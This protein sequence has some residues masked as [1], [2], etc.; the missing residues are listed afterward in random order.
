MSETSFGK[1]V[2]SLSHEFFQSNPVPK[3]IWVGISGGLD[4]VALLHLL[5]TATQSSKQSLFGYNLTLKAIHI[6]HQL[7]PNAT[8]WQSFCLE[9]CQ[10]LGIECISEKIQVGE[11][12]Q[13]GLERAAREARYQAM[14]SF[15]DKD[16]WLFLAHHQDDQAETLLLNLFRGTGLKGASAMNKS[17]KAWGLT[18]KRP[19][20]DYSK[21]ELLS[22]AKENDW[23]WVE[24]ESN[25]NTEL[26]RNFLRQELLPL[27]ETRWPGYRKT[28]SRFSSIMQQ[29]H[30]LIEDIAQQDLNFCKAKS[31]QWGESL[32]INHLISL[33]VIRQQNC[34]RFWL[35]KKL[36]YLPTEDSLNQFLLQIQTQNNTQ[37]VELVVSGGKLKQAFDGIYWVSDEELNSKQFLYQWQ[38]FSQPLVIEELGMKLLVDSDSSLDSQCIRQP[39]ADEVVTVRSWHSGDTCHP[40][41]RNKSIVLKKLWQELKV[42]V[43]QRHRIP[44]VFYNDEMIYAVGLFITRSG[45]IKKEDRTLRLSHCFNL[46]I[47]NK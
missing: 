7:S 6:N 34:I 23:C 32:T 13:I 30:G 18:I 1:A 42:P 19:L 10:K 16:E 33:S 45:Q 40:S 15:I 11:L 4:S 28:L 26:N 12:N 41:F 24:D 31:S 43:W 20:L 35:S 17:S 27:V 2:Q 36:E 22:W 47:L 3:V 21:A 39:R 38:S 44:L 8:H 9:L 29:Q 5:H 46:R 14:R 25:N 37:Q